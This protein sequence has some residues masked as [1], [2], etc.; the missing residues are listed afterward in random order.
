MYV[1]GCICLAIYKDGVY[2]CLCNCFILF[3]AFAEDSFGLAGGFIF[4]LFLFCLNELK[5][6]QIV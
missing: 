2:F 6:S 3:Y 5:D 4:K 1:M